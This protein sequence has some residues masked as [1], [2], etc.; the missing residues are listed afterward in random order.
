[1]EPGCPTLQADSLPSEPPGKTNNIYIHFK[2]CFLALLYQNTAFQNYLGKFFFLSLHCGY[3]INLYTIGSFVTICIP[4]W[5]THILIAFVC[6]LSWY[7]MDMWNIYNYKSKR[8]IKRH[9]K[10]KKLSI[11]HSSFSFCI[12]LSTL[13]SLIPYR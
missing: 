12:F 9:V 5:I 8:Y 1:M 2:N 6:L 4:F 10:K 11:L 7:L 3:V 13:V